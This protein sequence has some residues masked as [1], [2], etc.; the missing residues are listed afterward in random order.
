MA[1][2][3]PAV[4]A[5]VKSIAKRPW[6]AAVF[7]GNVTAVLL[8]ST[9]AR[10]K[11]LQL[12]M[13]A[14]IAVAAI[15]G[16]ASGK[17][18]LYMI[19]RRLQPSIRAARSSD[20]GIS[21]KKLTGIHITS[22]K[23]TAVYVTISPRSW[24]ESPTERSRMNSGTARTITGIACTVIMLSR[25]GCLPRNLKR[26]MAY[27]Q[28]A[29]AAMHM[30]VVESPT[31]TELTMGP[32]NIGSEK[33]CPYESSVMLVSDKS[34]TPAWSAVDGYTLY[35][36]IH[37]NGARK[38]TITTMTRAPQVHAVRW[39]IRFRDNHDSRIS[40]PSLPVKTTENKD[41]EHCDDQDKNHNSVRHR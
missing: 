20:G 19:C 7:T 18:I 3:T 26:A 9:F 31:I 17:A 22:G 15:P 6:N 13:N 36:I 12:V 41:P 5:E 10:K 1:V 40:C 34:G 24:S 14:R 23:I 29:P 35:A 11:S 28:A 16:A 25:S 8:V 32:R 21:S 30:T 38:M 27:A 4:A 2:M 33:S 37:T 39:C